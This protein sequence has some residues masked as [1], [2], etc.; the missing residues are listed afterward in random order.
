MPSENTIGQ[1]PEAKLDNF[2]NGNADHGRE[3]AAAL[4]AAHNGTQAE[5][6]PDQYVI[7]GEQPMRWPSGVTGRIA[8]AIHR[9]S[10]LPQQE[11]AIVA[12]LAALSGVMG[13]AYRTPTGATLSQYYLLVAPTGSGKDAIYKCIPKLLRASG[14]PS[15]DRFAVSERFASA[16]ALHRRI[17]ETPGFLAL[18]PEFGKRLATIASPRAKGGHDQQFGEF[19]TAAYEK[20]FM[21][22]ITRSGKDDS[23]PGMEWPALSFLGET[24]PQTFYR[25]LTVE[26]MEDG[27]F[28]RFLTMAVTSERPPSN[29]DAS[30]QLDSFASDQWSLIVEMALD[31][32]NI[33][34]NLPQNV[35]LAGNPP[36][37][38]PVQVQYRHADAKTDFS[39]F[40]EQCRQRVNDANRNGD[41]FGAAVWNRAHL[42]A[43]KVASLLAVADN[44]MSPTITG[45]HTDWAIYLIE[46]D[47]KTFLDKVDSGDVGDGDDTRQKKVLEICLRV[48][49][50]EL[51]DKRP[52][53][54][55]DGIITRRVLQSNTSRLAPFKNHPLGG[56]KALDETIKTL[57]ND[58]RLMKADKYK[59]AEIY[60]EQGDCY[61]YIDD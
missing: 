10:F 49:K 11:V 44:C 53:M 35:M 50:G 12:A 14:F 23:L 42:K 56:A 29:H 15:A 34:H 9:A 46:R 45:A 19:L 21:E 17:L 6:E 60:G 36:P 54:N 58:G 18:H 61:R 1:P 40:E 16:P 30:L 2:G 28:S 51:K 43:L 55:E 5:I 39:E 41:L 4:L 33:P 7:E 3:Q 26:M 32:N 24:T 27:F 52:R 47:A 37:L 20:E 22:G 48:I 38:Q 31:I 57:V 59:M 13:R 8:K 25:A